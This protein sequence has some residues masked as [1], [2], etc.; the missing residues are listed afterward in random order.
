MSSKA[1]RFVEPSRFGNRGI[2]DFIHCR[3]P[4][5]ILLFVLSA[6]YAIMRICDADPALSAAALRPRDRIAVARCHPPSQ[7][8]SVATPKVAQRPA[9]ALNDD[10]RNHHQKALFS[11]R[12]LNDV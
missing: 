1:A 5:R 11:R 12:A 4:S 10:A 8:H 7:N 2:E 9:A 3:R 6:T